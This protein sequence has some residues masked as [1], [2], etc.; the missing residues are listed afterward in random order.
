MDKNLTV[1]GEN[2]NALY[3]FDFI[4]AI[5]SVAGDSCPSDA[6]LCSSL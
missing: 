6:C 3:S 4:I 2:N 1:V 5:F